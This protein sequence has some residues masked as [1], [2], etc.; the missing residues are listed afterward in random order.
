MAMR[1]EFLYTAYMPGKGPVEVFQDMDSTTHVF[2]M[3][4]NGQSIYTTRDAVRPRKVSNR[5]NRV[6][7]AVKVAQPTLF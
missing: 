6:R 4:R 5:A 7:P 1:G 3:Q 2:A